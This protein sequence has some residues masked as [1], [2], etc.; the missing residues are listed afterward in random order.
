VKTAKRKTTR[1]RGFAPWSPTPKSLALVEQVRTVLATFRAHLPVTI[2]QIF[3]RLVST[4]GFPKTEKAYD[5]LCETLNRARRSGLL[6]WS[7]I[8]DDGFTRREPTSWS[9]P[10][11][12][13]EA[14][15]DSARRYRLD[16]QSDQ[17]RRLVVWCE[18]GGMVPQLARVA[19]DYS[20]PVFSSGGF[21]SVTAKHDAAQELALLG[22]ATVLHLGDL[23]PSGVHMF[24]SL[25]EDVRSFLGG[26]GAG[27]RVDFVRLA[28]TRDQVD[29]LDL[30]TS[31]P[32][33]TDRRSFSG[34]TV[35]CEAIPPDELARILRAAI[36]ERL[37]PDVLDAVL[38]R[39]DRER[40]RLVEH[41][42]GFLEPLR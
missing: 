23:D 36:V 24:G 19:G 41:V 37:D 6:S 28:V 12:W 25:D 20:V 21:D 18:A 39:E 40:T 8:R 15:L 3:Y 4:V 13:A 34:E 31:P 16:R 38:A 42:S 14:V 26:L 33:K 30:P 10:A 22:A 11:D 35:Q 5:R 1:E 17:D 29:E 7:D 2:R 32:K 27:G 9:S